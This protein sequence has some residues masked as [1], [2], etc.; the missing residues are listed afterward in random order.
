MWELGEL[1]LFFN[2]VT[3]DTGHGGF[4]WDDGPILKLDMWNW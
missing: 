3:R 4:E 2:L 1:S